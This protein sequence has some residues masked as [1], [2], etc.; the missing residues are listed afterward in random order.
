MRFNLGGKYWYY[1]E[2]RS[3]TWDGREL[4]GLCKL[5]PR[6]E[7]VILKTKN[8]KIQL[9]AIIHE[10]LHALSWSHGEDAVATIAESAAN[11]LYEVGLR[12]SKDSCDRACVTK[13]RTLLY[14]VL[15]ASRFHLDVD[16]GATLAARDIS[17]VLCRLGWQWR[18]KK[19]DPGE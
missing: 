19:S 4:V 12:R 16:D 13:V 6:R 9:D 2:S 3:I 8:Q 14:N 5:S 15:R 10:C 17:H 7:I 18:G 11:V 1:R